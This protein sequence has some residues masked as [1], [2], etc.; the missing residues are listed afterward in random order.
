[1]RL[2]FEAA[3]NHTT[4]NR[5]DAVASRTTP[6]IIRM[7]G[8]SGISISDRLGVKRVIQR[9][10]KMSSQHAHLVRIT[11]TTLNHD[12]SI[13]DSPYLCSKAIQNVEKASHLESRVG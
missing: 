11:S 9:R 4:S 5:S 8:E 13:L 2:E 10:R 12:N 1:M 3:K 7:T 6:S